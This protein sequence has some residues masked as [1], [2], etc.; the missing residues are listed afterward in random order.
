MSDDIKRDFKEFR[1]QQRI[2][3]KYQNEKQY[4]EAIAKPITTKDI[5]IMERAYQRVKESKQ[6]DPEPLSEEELKE[7]QREM[8]K[9][10]QAV[11]EFKEQKDRLR[12]WKL[13]LKEKYGNR[14]KEEKQEVSFTTYNKNRKNEILKKYGMDETYRAEMSHFA[15]VFAGDLINADFKQYRTVLRYK[16]KGEPEQFEKYYEIFECACMAYRFIAD[17]YK[18]AK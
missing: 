10:K 2:K 6:P 14:L 18:E 17:Y 8:L 16:A 5:M 4:H 12:A 11:K 13:E 3:E 15:K 9:Y 7:Y 1:R